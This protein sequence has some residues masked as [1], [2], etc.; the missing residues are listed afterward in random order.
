MYVALS[1][2]CSRRGLIYSQRFISG[3]RYADARFTLW[4]NSPPAL[5]PL[6]HPYVP[7]P[8]SSFATLHFVTRNLNIRRRR[9]ANPA[10]FFKNRAGRNLDEGIRED[11]RARGFSRWNANS[12]ALATRRWIV[13]SMNQS[14][15]KISPQSAGRE[16]FGQ[17]EVTRGGNVLHFRR[18]TLLAIPLGFS[19]LANARVQRHRFEKPLEN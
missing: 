10:K 12:A 8:G 9:A 2:G 5:V 18:V 19:G 17:A 4:F 3:V 14:S 1:R 7:C 11:R 16:A 15:S 6:S 13:R